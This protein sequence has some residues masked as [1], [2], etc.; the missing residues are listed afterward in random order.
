MNKKHI[1][2]LGGGFGGITTYKS[3]PRSI[4]KS[5]KVTIID[6]RNHFLF[7]PLLA[8]LAGSSLKSHHV[9]LS[10]KEVL[11]S[12][13][14]FIQNEVVSIDVQNSTVTLKEHDQIQY[15]F[16]VSSLG[17]NTSFYGTLG[18]QKYARVFKS[19]QDAIKIGIQIAS[20]K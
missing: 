8:E 3:L 13:A 10:I 4:K 6:K 15:D 11:G 16:L 19:L 1:V 17:A 12:S 18:A 2:I 9:A 14:E 5:C 20:S 7:T